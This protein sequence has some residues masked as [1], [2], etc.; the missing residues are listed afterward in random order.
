[1]QIIQANSTTRW[2]ECKSCDCTGKVQ[3]ID[4][5]VKNT[6]D[7]N[8][9]TTDD[10][11]AVDIVSDSMRTV[12]KAHIKRLM[13]GEWA[14]VE[15]GVQ[16]QP[17]VKAG[18]Q[19]PAAARAHWSESQET[20]LTFQSIYGLPDYEETATSVNTHQSPSWFRKAK[21]GI[22]IHWGIYS[23]PAFGNVGKKENYAEW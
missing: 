16:N 20:S 7:S 6:D 23:V 8:W 17:G 13:P 19:G 4:I 14:I 11:L 3:I 15:V 2:E 1:M 21:F 9:I 18:T 22:F 12:K 5:A 10:N